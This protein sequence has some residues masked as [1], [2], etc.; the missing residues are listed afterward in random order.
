MPKQNTVQYL[1]RKLGE[2]LVSLGKLEP[3]ELE[4]VLIA[5][6]NTSLRLGEYL[7]QRGAI[8]ED[9]LLTALSL[10]LGIEYHP[11]L[12]KDSG[13]VLSSNLPHGFIR[14]NNIVILKETPDTIEIAL[15]DVSRTEAVEN[16][17][18]MT[19]KEVVVVLARKLD[20]LR[21]AD[22]L[23]GEESESADKVIA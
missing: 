19:G 23:A 17:K 20:I 11:D 13:A 5:Q 12:L 22:L 8:T 3:D 18:S 21:I 1:G 2:I 15:N 10:Q 4:S 6:R 14:R 9:D 16:I 7:L